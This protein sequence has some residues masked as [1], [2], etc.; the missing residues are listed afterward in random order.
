MVTWLTYNDHESSKLLSSNVQESVQLDGFATCSERQQRQKCSVAQGARLQWDLTF[1]QTPQ[2]G[3]FLRAAKWS[4]AA[5][6]PP[7]HLCAASHPP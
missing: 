3:L 5:P 1:S 6:H 7:L 4:T 2:A